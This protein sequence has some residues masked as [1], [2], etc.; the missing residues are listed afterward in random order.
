MLQWIF[1]DLGS[2][3]LDESDRARECIESMAARI[4]MD[5]QAFQAMLERNAPQHPYVIKM[6][7]PGDAAWASWVPWPKRLDP[8]YPGAKPLLESLHGR[9]KLGVIAN[10]ATDIV[11]RIGLDPY[12]DVAMISQEVGFSKPDLRMFTTALERASCAPREAV[13]VGDRLDNDIAPAKR[14]GMKT[15]W[16][17]Q[18]WGGRAVPASE[19]MTPGMQVDTLEELGAL[20]IQ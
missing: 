2:T 19:E 12:F 5:L 11:R 17:R 8:L 6:E 16:I 10:H 15:I 4:G 13:M 1:F 3:L 7:L 18:G 9:Y 14:L 20:L